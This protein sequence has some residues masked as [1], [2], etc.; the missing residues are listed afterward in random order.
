MAV[1]TAA[2]K[3]IAWAA[4]DNIAKSTPEQKRGMVCVCW[5]EMEDECRLSSVQRYWVLMELVAV[6]LQSSASVMRT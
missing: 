6:L 2:G 1:P 3:K 4:L 5:I